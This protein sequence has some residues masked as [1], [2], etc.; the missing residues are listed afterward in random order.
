MAKPVSI[1]DSRPV[2]SPCVSVCALN[3]EDICT[4]CYRTADD[5]RL[6]GVMNNQEKRDAISKALEREKKVNPFL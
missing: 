1:L 6:W 5:I 2:A 4:G 3:D